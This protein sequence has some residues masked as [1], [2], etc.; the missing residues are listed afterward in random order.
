M[1]QSW[2]LLDTRL[3]GQDWPQ[4]LHLLITQDRPSTR[5]NL[6]EHYGWQHVQ[7]PIPHHH[8]IPH[9]MGRTSGHSFHLND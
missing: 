1:G 7:H 3:K 5:C 6:S 4:Q 8:C 9:L 2:I